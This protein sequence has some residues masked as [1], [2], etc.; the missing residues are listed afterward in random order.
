MFLV[1]CFLVFF[2][3]KTA[4]TTAHITVVLDSFTYIHTI[5]LFSFCF[6]HFFKKK[7]LIIFTGEKDGEKKTKQQTKPVCGDK[8]KKAGKKNH[9]NAEELASCLA[10]CT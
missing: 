9:L 6:Q 8:K 2:S 1:F 5:A 3:F 4:I 10:F 7:M